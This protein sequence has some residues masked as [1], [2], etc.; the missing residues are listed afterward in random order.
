MSETNPEIS[1]ATPENISDGAAEAIAK[2]KSSRDF[3][4]NL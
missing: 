2:K 3:C 1:E 4:E